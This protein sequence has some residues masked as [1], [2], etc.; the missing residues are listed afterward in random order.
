MDITP[1]A[2]FGSFIGMMTNSNS[3][4]T[5]GWR[6]ISFTAVGHSATFADPP[7]RMPRLLSVAL[8]LAAFLIAAAHADVAAQVSAI[9]AS[10]T[11]AQNSAGVTGQVR[12]PHPRLTN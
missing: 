7:A 3:A 9:F 2:L 11:Q 6:I 10:E 1:P 12:L 8:A 5:V 4:C